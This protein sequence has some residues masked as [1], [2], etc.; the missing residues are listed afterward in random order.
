MSTQKMGTVAGPFSL[1]TDYGLPLAELVGAGNYDSVSPDITE[2]HF[3]VGWGPP[4]AESF[5]VHFH[6][7]VSSKAVVDEMKR[8]DLRPATMPELLAFGAQH[9]G[10]QHEYFPILALG[11]IWEDPTGYRRMARIFGHP[12]DRRL[13]LGWDDDSEW[14]QFYRFLAVEKQICERVSFSIGAGKS[15]AEMVKC[16]NYGR[17]DKR[18]LQQAENVAGAWETDAI[19]VHF[20]RV[21]DN[22]VVLRE[23]E[24]RGL[25]P[26]TLRELA[27]FGEQH[28]DRQLRF[29]ILA[30][31]SVIHG[32]RVGCLQPNHGRRA[33]DLN[34]YR[35]RWA[36]NYRFLAFEMRGSRH[37]AEPIRHLDVTLEWIDSVAYRATLER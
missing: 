18:I 17:V 16:S 37:R 24:R 33:F 7:P 6:H 12:N 27:V 4:N 25:R 10:P 15:L 26:S 21:L 11:S 34:I 19:L 8:H 35:K 23:L 3:P 22:A 14:G 31:G 29:P 13:D 32:R 5:L 36:A 1:I 30:L 20:A 2:A 9:H 28:P